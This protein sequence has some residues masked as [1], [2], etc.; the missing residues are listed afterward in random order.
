MR[1]SG[2]TTLLSY[3]EAL[4]FDDYE[5]YL[6]YKALADTTA[7]TL[8]PQ[9]RQRFAERM[10]YAPTESEVTSWA[11]SLPAV[12]QELLAAA[13]NDVEV[14]VEYFLTLTSKRA[15]AGHDGLSST[16]ESTSGTLYG[17]T[18]DTGG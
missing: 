18:L 7:G 10:L 14:I 13:L 11:R 15:D 1:D 4:E 17:T 12:A 6:A 8:V 9:L 3:L 5:T 16:N 2:S